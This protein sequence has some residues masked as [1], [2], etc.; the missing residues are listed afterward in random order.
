[1]ELKESIILALLREA[2]LVLFQRFILGLLLL[3]EEVV[4][5]DRVKVVV[6]F[7]VVVEVLGVEL[8]VV[9][10]EWGTHMGQ[11]EVEQ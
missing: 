2:L 6:L 1:V 8:R 3:E 5:Q 7:S 9:L 11:A 10:V 4:V